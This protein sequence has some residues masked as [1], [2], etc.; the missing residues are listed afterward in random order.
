ME[1]ENIFWNFYEQKNGF[2]KKHTHTLKVVH[3]LLPCFIMSS[4]LNRAWP[5]DSSPASWEERQTA[6]SHCF[7]FSHCTGTTKCLEC[8]S[9][10]FCRCKPITLAPNV[11]QIHPWLSLAKNCWLGSPGSL[12]PLSLLVRTE[13]EQSTEGVRNHPGVPGTEDLGIQ[14]CHTCLRVWAKCLCCLEPACF[15]DCHLLF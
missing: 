13:W 2:R 1:K 3:S 8:Q 14:V 4:F 9:D 6:G 5:D 7:S 11:V 15:A 10:L 12:V